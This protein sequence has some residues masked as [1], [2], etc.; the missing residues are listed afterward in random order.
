MTLETLQL[1]Q[2]DDVPLTP[3]KGEPDYLADE[4][5]LEDTDSVPNGLCVD[6]LLISNEDTELSMPTTT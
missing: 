6:P 5:A 3:V 1:Q 2:D 4:A